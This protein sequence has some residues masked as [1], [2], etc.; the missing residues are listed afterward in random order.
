MVVR[1]DFAGL[2]KSSWPDH[3]SISFMI[4]DRIIAVAIRV[5]SQYFRKEFMM[6]KKIVII[7]IL[8]ILCPFL[9]QAQVLIQEDFSSGSIDTSVWGY[10][11]NVDAQFSVS[12]EDF[13]QGGDSALVYTPLINVDFY[14][15]W[16]F[17]SKQS[18]PRSDGNGNVLRV[19]I[20]FYQH[21]ADNFAYMGWVADKGGGYQFAEM[22]YLIHPS[23]GNAY[24]LIWETFREN[25]SPSSFVGGTVD[26]WIKF[27]LTLKEISGETTGAIFEYHD[28]NNWDVM[29]NADIGDASTD[30]FF[31]LILSPRG[32]GNHAIFD[33]ITIEYV[34]A[35]EPTPTPTPE[36]TA[37][38]P[39]SASGLPIIE[40]FTSQMI[41]T[42]IW[43][44]V[45]T[46][47]G[48][49]SV[50]NQDVGQG[51]DWALFYTPTINVD[52]YTEWRFFSLA[53]F[54]RNDG[55]GH[56]LR[57]T[58]DYYAAGGI[59]WAYMGFIADKG[60]GFDFS[61]LKHL[62]HPSGGN[63]YTLTWEDF[64]A[65]GSFGDTWAPGHDIG[66]TVD[67]WIQ[68]RL[69]LK[70][71]TGC[72]YEYHNGSNWTE[73]YQNDIGDDSAEFYCALILSPRGEGNFAIFDNIMI[74]HV[75][76]PVVTVNSVL[77]W[78]LY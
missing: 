7:S 66:G 30:F 26:K 42:T 68:L 53:S 38:P 71:T 60:G 64:R 63:I 34:P 47:E 2:A 36:P 58:V 70:E 57:L 37:T 23:G 74:E 5:I 27:R 77:N 48:Q 61:Q 1:L 43:G 18:W 35:V 19:T 28:G 45:D 52:D 44:F 29:R 54:P 78:T 51:G 31:A 73:L 49:F 33:N 39:P 56:P 65:G 24:N 11:D 13:G 22:K 8:F 6:M 14:E 72:I 16:G 41:D 21:G 46:A 32:D 4:R 50:S 67:R 10:Y 55:S 12:N 17:Y 62:S 9:V 76:A 59:N 25:W 69:T 15:E 20:D 3:H 75:G 40:E